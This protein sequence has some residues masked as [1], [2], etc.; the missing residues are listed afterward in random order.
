[1]ASNDNGDGLTW[2]T[3]KK[4]INAGVTAAGT[5]GIVRVK[6]GTYDMYDI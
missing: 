1:M 4:S 6:A 3:A 2:E 5:N